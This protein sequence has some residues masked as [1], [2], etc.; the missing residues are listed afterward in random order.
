V[1]GD[2]RSAQEGGTCFVVSTLLTIGVVTRDQNTHK[3]TRDVFGVF[4]FDNR[5]P[6]SLGYV[7]VRVVQRLLISLT[8][9][10]LGLHLL[11]FFC[12]TYESSCIGFC[13]TSKC[14]CSWYVMLGFVCTSM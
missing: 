6:L 11:K 5:N 8:S 4:F 12:V 2:R 1:V 13:C 10:Y 9:G 7:V 3:N 14:M